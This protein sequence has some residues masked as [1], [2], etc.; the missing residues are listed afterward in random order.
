MRKFLLTITAIISINCFAAAQPQVKIA[1][2][3]ES[4]TRI[5]QL[6]MNYQQSTL[7]SNLM[8]DFSNSYFS[9][10]YLVSHPE[11]IRKLNNYCNYH[12]SKSDKEIYNCAQASLYSNFWYKFY[13][14]SGFMLGLISLK[15]VTL[16]ILCVGTLFLFLLIKLMSNV[17][18]ITKIITRYLTLKHAK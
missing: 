16:V 10:Q 8:L 4:D 5:E 7:E 11:I 17:N 3:F 12:V 1:A 6:T 15:W 2:P 13:V 18:V 9:G 14:Y